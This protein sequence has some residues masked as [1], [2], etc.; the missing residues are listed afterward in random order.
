MT[1]EIC[2]IAVML[3]VVDNLIV[4]LGDTGTD[5]ESRSGLTWM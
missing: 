2:I 4:N 1:T 3:N 5:G